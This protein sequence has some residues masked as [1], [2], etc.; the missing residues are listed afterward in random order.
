MQFIETHIL[1]PHQ[2]KIVSTDNYNKIIDF[3]QDQY[4]NGFSHPTDI[5]TGRKKLSIDE[6][7][8]VLSDNDIV[9]IMQRPSL[10]VGLI[11]GTFVTLLANIAISTALNYAIGRVF[12][13]EIPD[14]SRAN[15][16]SQSSIYTLNNAQNIA[17]LGSPIPVVYGT[18][19]M[20]PSMINQPYY[21]Y[22]DDDEYLY[23]LLCVGHGTFTLDEL[24]IGSQNMDDSED[25]EVKLLTNGNF[26][27]IQ[28]ATLDTNYTQLTNT[29]DTPQNLELLGTWLEDAEI[30]YIE[31]NTIRVNIEVE[32]EIGQE[33]KVL[34]DG[35]FTVASSIIGDNVTDIIVNES[36]TA[37]SVVSNFSAPVET[38]KYPINED[39]QYIEIDFNY[40]YGIYRTSST[41]EF[42]GL[43]DA[44]AVNLYDENQN[45]LDTSD[46][47]VHRGVDNTNK[48]FTHKLDA[49]GAKYVSL[50]RANGKSKLASSQNTLFVT[51]IK[52]LYPQPDL[53]N[54][55]NL[56]LMWV[57][58]KA[59]NAISSAGQLQVNGF[60]TR[61]DVNNDIK[62]VLTDI[63]TNI[64]YG[65]KLSL[66]DLDFTET[67]ETVNGAFENQSTVWDAMKLV[68]KAQKYTVYP[69]GQDIVLKRDAATSI[70]TA[71]FNE[72]NILENTLDIQYFFKEENEQ[73]D[74]VECE[75]RD[76]LDWSLK[77][78]RYPTNGLSPHK[79]EL[80]G[81]TNEA[82]ALEVATYLY[83]QDNARRKIITFETDI[84][85]LVPQFLDKILISHSTLLW[86]SAG[87][88]DGVDGSIV[89]LSE[90]IDSISTITFRNKNGEPSNSLSATL[91]D[92]YN[93]D[94]TLLPSWVEDGAPYTAGDA[95]EYLVTGVKPQGDTVRLECVNY[96][97]SI[98]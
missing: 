29:L 19:R 85:G 23:H 71:L 25:I 66:S 75:Y 53:S 51:R 77:S 43:G 90:S 17:K 24:L 72:T 59:T 4:P 14:Y 97:E 52:E 54:L 48:R 10:P 27:N 47:Y 82:K 36:V 61:T 40:P 44:V 98:Y 78:Q 28:A 11:G 74:S 31:P 45:L 84:Q 18:V 9:I 12:A 49:T 76:S 46:Y 38:E 79:I 39:S 50:K 57:K 15:H 41:G 56:T 5:Y 91:I 1:N 35:S 20:Y 93:I 70:S 86:G 42:A 55:G 2:R 37:G 33:I 95:K 30:I 80:F 22:T 7:D 32:L 83:K 67:P 87:V 8:L 69:I 88:V 16:Q 62:S 3:L 21:R 73:I 13:P 64:D 68:S 60:F 92:S 94:V 34:G 89:T 63:Y 26:S 96:D 58:I 81:V 6:Y 65:A